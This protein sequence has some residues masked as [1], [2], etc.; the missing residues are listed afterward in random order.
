MFKISKQVVNFITRAVDNCH[1][2]IKETEKVEK[3]LDFARKLKKSWIMKVTPI[4]FGEHGT[5]PKERENR[6]EE[7][8][9][10]RRIKRT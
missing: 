3:Y 2:A 10:R 7:L 8:V 4:L 6:F 1:L 9:I 5:V